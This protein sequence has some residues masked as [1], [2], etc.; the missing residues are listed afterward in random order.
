MRARRLAVLI[1]AAML[2]AFGA[3]GVSAGAAQVETTVVQR[4]TDSFTDVNPCTGDPAT[5]T[6]TYSIVV[7]MTTLP[8]GEIHFSST[9]AGDVLLE[10]LD[11]SLPTYTGHLVD[12]SNQIYNANED[13]ATFTQRARVTGSDGS[14][15]RF[16]VIAHVT[17]DT[18]DVSTDPPTTTGLK[19]TFLRFSCTS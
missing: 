16:G 1:A 9:L 10:P 19:V 8:S 5:I 2:A 7:H 12:F 14:V 13:V 17:A 18:V 15:I 11:P 3:S 4:A 6:L